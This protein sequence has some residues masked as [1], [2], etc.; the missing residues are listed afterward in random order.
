MTLTYQKP[1]SAT[2]VDQ[3]VGYNI[4]AAR[5]FIGWSQTELGNV[6]NV[7]FQQVQKYETGRNRIS[8]G[9]IVTI[10]KALSIGVDEIFSNCFENDIEAKNITKLSSKALDA[11]LAFDKLPDDRQQAALNVLRALRPVD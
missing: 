2:E 3:Q 5:K 8:A 6:L 7:S 4:K 10:C 11:G 9:N 1:R